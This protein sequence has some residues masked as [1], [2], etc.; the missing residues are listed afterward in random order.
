MIT[1]MLLGFNLS[2][3]DGHVVKLC[4]YRH[5]SMSQTLSYSVAPSGSCPVELVFKESE[6]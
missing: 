2:S 4:H 5:E 6:E 3:I 1:L